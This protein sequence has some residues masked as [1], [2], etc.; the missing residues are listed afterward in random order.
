MDIVYLQAYHET[1][2]TI[3]GIIKKKVMGVPVE[4]EDLVTSFMNAKQKYT[5]TKE[6]V[7]EKEEIGAM[8]ILS[9]EFYEHE[10]IKELYS[11]EDI[12]SAL[13][14]ISASIKLFTGLIA[15]AMIFK[16]IVSLG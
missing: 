16:Y 8:L 11:T 2:M 5:N 1:Q 13:G 3:E 4:Y 9:Y 7:D 10:F 15:T 6:I 12:V 14:G